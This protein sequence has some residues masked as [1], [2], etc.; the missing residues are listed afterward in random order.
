MEMHGQGGRNRKRS[1][2]VA[3][4]PVR[5]GVEMAYTMEQRGSSG[6]SPGRSAFVACIPS[7]MGT[8]LQ[9]FYASSAHPAEA[10]HI[11]VLPAGAAPFILRP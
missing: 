3:R 5:M 6:R 10:G 1:A 9:L 4:I 7:R 8:D 11:L 2:Y